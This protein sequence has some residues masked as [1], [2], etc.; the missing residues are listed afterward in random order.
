MVT[1]WY[2]MVWDGMMVIS[3]NELDVLYSIP[4]YITVYYYSPFYVVSFFSFSVN[5]LPIPRYT[6]SVAI[7]VLNSPQL[8]N[9]QVQY[10]Q[11]TWWHPN[12][13]SD[14][15]TLYTSRPQTQT[16][17]L[18]TSLGSPTL[19]TW[20]QSFLPGEFLLLGLPSILGFPSRRLVYLST[21]ENVG[22][23]DNILVSWQYSTPDSYLLDVRLR[24]NYLVC[25]VLSPTYV[26]SS[27][28]SS[29]HPMPC[30][31]TPCHICKPRFFFLCFLLLHEPPVPRQPLSFEHDLL[32][33]LS[34]RPVLPNEFFRSMIMIHSWGVCI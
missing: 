21:V 28:S 20:I 18:D 23:D 6:C 7:S 5:S 27:M 30:F 32:L 22:V 16:S 9:L 24:T 12:S 4:R 26:K 3:I 33:D 14:P 15:P 11:F 2:G 10:T 13:K 1:V 31:L 19:Q 17:G 29:T 34:T 25:I 8:L